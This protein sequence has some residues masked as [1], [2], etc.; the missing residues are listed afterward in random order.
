MAHVPFW[1]G[2][3]QN[4]DPHVGK[5]NLPGCTCFRAQ[6]RPRHMRLNEKIR[7]LKDQYPHVSVKQP[8][9]TSAEKIAAYRQNDTNKDTIGEGPW[10]NEVLPGHHPKDES[11]TWDWTR[12]SGSWRIKCNERQFRAATSS[13]P[14]WLKVELTSSLGRSRPRSTRRHALLRSG[15]TIQQWRP[16]NDSR[17][18]AC[19]PVPPRLSWR[20]WK[21]S[22][23]HYT[24]N[25][26][27]WKFVKVGKSGK[28][29]GGGLL[30]EDWSS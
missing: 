28:K 1:A 16:P 11:S 18:W 10:S 25:A 26:H 14:S 22:W 17:T 30:S 9:K 13:P 19:Q 20:L 5:W 4:R 7:K 29:N 3:L 2:N 23:S 12:K 27:I 6:S 15:C 8:A 21:G 24:T